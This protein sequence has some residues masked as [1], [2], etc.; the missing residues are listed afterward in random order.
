M[1]S[2]EAASP[3]SAS[4][5]IIIPALEP[6]QALVKYVH[7]LRARGFSQIVVV[8]DG[9]SP[10]CAGIFAALAE[11]RD[12]VVLRHEVNRGK[13]AALKTALRHCLQQGWQQVYRRVIMV[14]ADGQH[15]VEDVCSM[16][17]A[18]HEHPD[19]Y[20]LGIRDFNQEIVPARSRFGN[21]L[22]S[23][24]FH[25]FYGRYL[26]DTQTGLRALPAS[27]WRWATEVAGDRFEYE[28]NCLVQAMK[29]GIPM[30]EMPIQTLYFDRN[31][32]T[33]YRTLRDSWPIFKVLISHLGAYALAGAISSV[34]ALA[35]FAWVDLAWLKGVGDAARILAACVVSAWTGSLARLL[36]HWLFRVRTERNMTDATVKFY[37]LAAGQMLASYL[38]VLAVHSVTGWTA[39]WIKL[40]A[41]V[42]LAIVGY[43]IHP[44]WLFRTHR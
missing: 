10:A 7:D 2:A 39:V 8:D 5:I 43:Q 14:D 16:A 42:A 31:A 11:L 12:C 15:A 9:S 1:N 44:R 20:V 34:L 29:R 33:H 41:D 3:H 40:V 19:A 36:L 24:A 6:A 37:L 32:G 21:R 22:T 30:A 4:S 13:G 27:L 17:R 38:V 23:G 26:R 28:T 18:S 35:A 25:L